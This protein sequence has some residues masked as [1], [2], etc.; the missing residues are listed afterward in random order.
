MP[1]QFDLVMTPLPCWF[2]PIDKTITS[3]LKLGLVALVKQILEGKLP[4]VI[5][6]CRSFKQL[7]NYLLET[8]A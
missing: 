2:P 5:I 6:A 1:E 7:I 4:A 8:Y 3:D